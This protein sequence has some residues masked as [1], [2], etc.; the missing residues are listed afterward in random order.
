[1]KLFVD[2]S[3]AEASDRDI[4]L[5]YWLVSLFEI[6]SVFKRSNGTF[7]K[8]TDVKRTLDFYFQICTVE[9]NPTSASVL[10]ATLA[11]EGVAPHSGK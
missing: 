1:M 10:A 8:E 7:P 2:G 4:A 11:N 5:A 3:S 6:F 9:A